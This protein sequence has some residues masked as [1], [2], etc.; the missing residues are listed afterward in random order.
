MKGMVKTLR[1]K[2]YTL[3]SS[4]PPR[5]RY[6]VARFTKGGRTFTGRGD[7][8]ELAVQAAVLCAMEAE[9]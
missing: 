7:T 5:S 4:K 9:K 1:A 6:Y 3:T 2:G 8:V